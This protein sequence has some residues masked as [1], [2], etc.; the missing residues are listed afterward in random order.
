MQPSDDGMVRMRVSRIRF[1]VLGLACV[2]GFACGGVGN[3][4]QGPL[5]KVTPKGTSQPASTA[6]QVLPSADAAT[7]SPEASVAK[8]KSTLPPVSHET[9]ED[10]FDDP[11]GW[12]EEITE[13]YGMGRGEGGVYRMEFFLAGDDEVL[14]SLQPHSFSLPLED[15]I[16]RAEGVG[17]SKDGAYGLVCRYT[18]PSNY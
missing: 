4:T 10:S 15:M 11:A 13:R 5:I 17:M 8:L 16:V 1:L 2:L 18:D 3:P 9:F 7:A 14:L 6:A 12:A